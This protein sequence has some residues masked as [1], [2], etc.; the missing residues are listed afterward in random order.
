MIKNNW[1]LWFIS[2]YNKGNDFERV[3]YEGRGNGCGHDENA[4]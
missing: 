3:K 2:F 1:T 4:L